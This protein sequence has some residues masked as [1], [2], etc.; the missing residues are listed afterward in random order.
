MNELW[1]IPNTW[2]WENV[3]SVVKWS[4]GGT[5]KATK[6]SY[7]ENGT[8]PW[9]ITADLNDGIV[10]ESAKKINKIG[11]DNSSTKMVEVGSVFVAM[12][13][14]IG[15]L[16]IAGIRCCTNQAIAFSREL[17][18]V[19]NKYLFYYMRNIKDYL[20]S[21]GKGG[22]QANISLTVLNS[23]SIPLP[24][25]IDEQKRI[26]E[27]LELL[28]GKIN[29][30]NERLEKIPTI[31]KRFHQSVL[32]SACSGKLTADWREENESGIWENKKLQE[33]CENIVDCPHSTPKWTN[34]GKICI[35]TT[36]FKVGSLD[37]SE[38]RY[39]SNETFIDRTSR[40]V[41][42]AND[43]LYSRE[44]GIL[45]IACQVPE[46]VEL[47]LG[48]RM[49]ILRTKE[50]ISSKYVMHVLNS[51]LITDVVR[52][53]TGGTAAPHLNVGDVKNFVI[54]I[55][56][57]PEQE[58]IVRRVDKLFALADKIEQRYKNAKAQL[59]RAEKSIFAKAF[60]GELV[61]QEIEEQ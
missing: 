45:G 14:S 7:Y 25:I 19:D 48:Q 24:H 16:G 5:P 9:L 6:M 54:P 10:Q 15:K 33:L 40:L 3:S 52:E 60:Q 32:S 12:Y 56:P 59:A 23:I 47:C 29:K 27:R 38:V 13:G 31:L 18:G 35:R 41:P 58:E 26:V 2:R 51:S 42:V 1:Q 43:I 53:K 21:L 39:V 55:P 22:T 20:L 4:S 57:L 61:R 50:D 36:N 28:F 17:K 30:A 49:M 46:N 44:G 37:L 34:A 8:I 11:F